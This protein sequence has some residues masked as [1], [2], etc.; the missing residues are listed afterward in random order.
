VTA[1]VDRLREAIDANDRAIVDAVNTRLR[2][3]SELWHVKR[4]LQVDRLDRDREQSLREA[5][6]ATNAGPLSREG[7]QRLIDELLALTKTELRDV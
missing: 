6:A 5:L 1:E 7:L 2:L 4:T 3:V